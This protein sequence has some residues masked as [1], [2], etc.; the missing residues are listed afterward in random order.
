[1][2]RL[3]ETFRTEQRTIVL[4]THQRELAEPLA[5]F[6]LKLQAGAV[7]SLEEGPYAKRGAGWRWR[8]RAPRDQYDDD[9]LKARAQDKCR[10]VSGFAG[11]PV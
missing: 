4:T 5:D 6:V 1:M 3:L 2:L 11:D 9:E 10:A 7:V 8:R